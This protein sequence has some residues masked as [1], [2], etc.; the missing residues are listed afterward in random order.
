MINEQWFPSKLLLFGEHVLLLGASAI[1][2]PYPIY[3]GRWNW[4]QPNTDDR[5]KQKQLKAFADS[6]LLS[7]LGF[8]KVD[9]FSKDIENGLFFDSNIP[10]GYGLGSSGALC[11]AVYD[12]YATTPSA[13]MAVLK[14]QLSQMESFFHGSSS[15]IDPLTSFVNTPILVR[16]KHNITT[17]STDV[18]TNAP[19]ISLWDT[20]IPR[21]TGPLVQWFK[22]KSRESEFSAWLQSIYLPVHERVVQSWIEADEATFWPSLKLLS[23]YQLMHFEPMIPQAIRHQWADSLESGTC[24]YKIC[25]AGGGGF[26]LGFHKKTIS[27]EG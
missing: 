12:R 3:G 4:L 2:V 10:L 5:S 7:D 26:V 15:G 20:K 18:W 6:P 17:L 27:N 16:N 24:Y 1:A 14:V 25:G 19:E 21:Q 11:A 9:L 22:E 8:L 23:Q 13:D